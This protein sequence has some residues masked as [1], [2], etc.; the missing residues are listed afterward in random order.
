MP[1][2]VPVTVPP[3]LEP[4]EVAFKSAKLRQAPFVSTKMEIWTWMQLPA[5]LGEESLERVVSHLP[6]LLGPEAEEGY[7]EPGLPSTISTEPR[8]TSNVVFETKTSKFGMLTIQV[9]P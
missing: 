8:T 4:A 3:P 7:R 1:R 5:L 6:Y 2:G 9:R